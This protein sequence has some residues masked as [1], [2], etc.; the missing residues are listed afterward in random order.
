MGVKKCPKCGG[1]WS[2]SLRLCAFC[3]AEGVEESAP[4]HVTLPAEQMKPPEPEPEPA[5]EPQEVA[6]ETAPPEPD[7]PASNPP[8]VTSPPADTPLRLAALQGLT[9]MPGPGPKVAFSK[10]GL[11]FSILG[12][13]A[14]LAL[15]AVVFFQ[16]ETGVQEWIGKLGPLVSGLLAPFA[17]IAW[18][19]GARHEKRCREIDTSPQTGARIARALGVACTIILLFEASILLIVVGI[20]RLT[21]H[22]PSSFLGPHG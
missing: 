14:C 21:G 13:L 16:G 17:A 8:P 11:V 1:S 12:L 22:L 19:L 6:V 18:I 15:P 7:L 5:K 2:S 10:A 3:G 4:A 20:L 9:P